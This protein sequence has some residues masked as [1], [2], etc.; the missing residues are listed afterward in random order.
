[1][2]LDDVA[3]RAGVTKATIYRFAGAR[4]RCYDP[5]AGRRMT[6][7]HTVVLTLT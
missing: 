7:R 1:M 4:G 6:S 5:A 3:A 2:A